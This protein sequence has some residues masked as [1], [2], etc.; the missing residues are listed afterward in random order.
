MQLDTILLESME[1]KT[2]PRAFRSVDIEASDESVF[3]ILLGTQDG[4]IFHAVVEYSPAGFEVLEPLTCVLELPD[5]KAILDIKIANIS[6]GQ[7]IVLAVT[8]SSLY[9]FA[10]ESMIKNLLMRY[11]GDRSMIS[12]SQLT[13]DNTIQGSDMAR[14]MPAQEDDFANQQKVCLHIFYDQREPEKDSKP[15]GF[16]WQH[17]LKFCYSEFKFIEKKSEVTGDV[18][19]Q[20]KN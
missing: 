8:D 11:K 9:Q 14:H 7:N 18:E 16:G 20:I 17:E 15:I 10:G 4:Q 1:T 6:F 19:T 5:G 3:E 12:K 2:R 13:L